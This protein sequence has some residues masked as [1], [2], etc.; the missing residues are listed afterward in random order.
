MNPHD[1]GV[2]VAVAVALIAFVFFNRPKNWIARS[3]LVAIGIV[4][5]VI[6]MSITGLLDTAMGVGWAMVILAVI[7]VP[8]A[9]FNLVRKGRGNVVVAILLLSVAAVLLVSGIGVLRDFGVF[10]DFGTGLS[11]FFRG[12]S[13]IS[14]GV[15]NQVNSGG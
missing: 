13:K 11:E 5:V 6:L 4:A 9:I 1:I 14:D 7:F 15:T 8:V 3:V 2:V 10:T 12:A